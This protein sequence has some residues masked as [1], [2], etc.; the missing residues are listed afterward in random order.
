MFA[1]THPSKAFLS[2]P[3]RRV[4]S[5]NQI[6]STCASRLCLLIL[7]EFIKSTLKSS[8]RHSKNRKISRLTLE[9]RTRNPQRLSVSSYRNPF[10]RPTPLN[11]DDSPRSLFIC[12]RPQSESLRVSEARRAPKNVTPALVS[13]RLCSGTKKKAFNFT[14][15]SETAMKCRSNPRAHARHMLCLLVLLLVLARIMS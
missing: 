9:D 13:L 1:P 10:P 6:H 5:S 14:S 4:C 8:C 3:H 15:F 12:G 11:V 7:L 2:H